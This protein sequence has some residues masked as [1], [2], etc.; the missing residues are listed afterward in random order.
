VVATSKF[1]TVV[2]TQSY[3]AKAEKLMNDEDRQAVVNLLAADPR[4]GDVI[5][6][7]GGI[8]KIR[9]ALQG[10]G[11]R[12]G[13]RVIYFF[14]TEAIPLFLLDVFAKNEKANISAADLAQFAVLAKSIVKEAK[15]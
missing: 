14:Y 10:R 11:K 4:A 8:R 3:L 5:P 9:I 15:S 2:E 6:G 1:I 13:A 12:G 7:G